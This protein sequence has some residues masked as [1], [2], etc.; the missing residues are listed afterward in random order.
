MINGNFCENDLR[1]VLRKVFKLLQL[2][3]EYGLQTLSIWDI[4]SIHILDIGWDKIKLSPLE[5][6]NPARIY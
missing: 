5:H 4:N 2:T 6:R 1:D 3:M